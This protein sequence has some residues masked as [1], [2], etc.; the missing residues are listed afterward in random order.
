MMNC[1]TQNDN[2]SVP[3]EN[4]AVESKPQCAALK[5][6]TVVKRIRKQFHNTG[7]RVLY[8]Q[9]HDTTVDPPVDGHRLFIIGEDQTRPETKPLS[10]FRQ[11]L[12]AY[13]RSIGVLQDHE[14]VASSCVAWVG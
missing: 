3:I 7:V 2:D 13:A 9:T 8:C 14:S 4:V 1:E 6:T 11:N 12:E 5:E 10:P